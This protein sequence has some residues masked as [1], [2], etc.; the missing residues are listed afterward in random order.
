MADISDNTNWFETDNANDR[1]PPNGWPEGQM[2]ST[3]N[4]CARAGMGALKRFWDRI[5]PSTPSISP[6][7]GLWQY[8]TTEVAYP[9]AYAEGEI[10][11]ILAGASAVGGDQFQVNSLGAVPIYKAT[12]GG[13]IPTVALDW[14]TGSMPRFAYR[15]DLNAGAGGF[16]L[17][18]N[19]YIPVIS[20]AAGDLTFPGNVVFSSSVGVTGSLAVTGGSV[21][22]GPVTM[23]GGI[24]VTG[25]GSVDNLTVTNNLT[26]DN[27]AIVYGSLNVSGGLTIVTGALVIDAGN[28]NANGSAVFSGS[29]TFSGGMTV[30]GNGVFASNNV[31]LGANGINYFGDGNEIGFLWQSGLIHAYVNRGDQGGIVLQNGNPTLASLTVSNNLQVNGQISSNTVV[32]NGITSNGNATVNGQ[33]NVGSELYVGGPTYVQ[34]LACAS[35]SSS[36][37]ISCASLQSNGDISSHSNQIYIQNNGIQ[38]FGG[39]AIAF[40]WVGAGDLELFVNRSLVAYVPVSPSLRLVQAEQVSG[41]PTNWAMDFYDTSGTLYR[42]LCDAVSDVRLKKN[43]HDTKI[44]ALAAILATPVREFEWK[45]E[46]QTLYGEQP[47]AIGLVAQEVKASMPDVVVVQ[48]K[49]LGK[50]LP[51]DMHWLNLPGM[52]PYLIRAMQQLE[53]RV[54]ELEHFDA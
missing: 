25:S 51:E 15:A 24:A 42:C 38:Y 35:L 52:V 49:A 19:P 12:P 48:D 34:G 41:G 1:P 5:N 26:V 23:D 7:S 29:G 44:D 22:T 36:G 17:L 14:V 30:A 20:D 47:I 40:D 46:H 6:S 21:F 10:F 3:V 2:P 37:N 28:I 39:Q 54:A 33:L 32:A 45:K 53:A 13:P 11:S 18:D 31:V 50:H 27:T 16:L 4:D 8:N 43:I 9:A